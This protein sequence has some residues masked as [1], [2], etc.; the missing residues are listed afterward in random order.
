LL[1]RP[2]CCCPTAEQSNCFRAARVA[3]VKAAADA[4]VGERLLPA[5]AVR[6]V[7]EAERSDRF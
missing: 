2:I 1:L 7:R 5:D 3:K 6:Y 4:L